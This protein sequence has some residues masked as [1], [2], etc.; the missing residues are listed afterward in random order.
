[1]TQLLYGIRAGIRGYI[2][3]LSLFTLTST[4]SLSVLGPVQAQPIS[5]VSPRPASQARGLALELL[6]EAVIPVGSLVVDSTEVGGLSGIT[7]DAANDL[8][9]IISDDRSQKAPARFYQVQLDLTGESFSSEQVQFQGLSL[10]R[11]ENG[12]TFSSLSLDPEGIALTEQ[13]TLWIS[14]EGDATRGIAPFVQEFRQGGETLRSLPLPSKLLPDLANQR[15]VGRNLALESLTITPDQRYLVTATENALLQDGPEASLSESSPARILKYDSV[16]QAWV[17]EYVY[18]TDPVALRP[19]PADGF[20]ASGLVELL[21]LNNE[22]TR[23]LALERSFSAGA[24][25]TAGDT[26]MTIRLYQV[27][28]AGA[29]N[30]AEIE[31]LKQVDLA[32]II[33][34]EKTLL[35]DFAS[36]KLP[37]G[38]LEG[39]T[40][41]PRLPDG[42]RSLIVVSDDNFSEGQFTQFLVFA[43][44]PSALPLPRPF[45]VH[46]P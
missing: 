46:Q 32:T 42:R 20:T 8:Y 44:D 16:E 39:L 17:G 45:A 5:P 25:G 3:S 11:D 27:S 43:I 26:G 34:A 38:N 37:L 21:V 23:F 4:L 6:G 40:F 29:T 7:Y 41:G 35:L 14:S 1:M 13:G 30:V 31:S 22:A 12:E 10:L 24:T 36:L 9:F 18:Q 2:S 33:P 15:G 28:L 19:N